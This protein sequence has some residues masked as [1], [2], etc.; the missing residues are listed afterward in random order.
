MVTG[1]VAMLATRV[2]F[3]LGEGLFPAAAAKALANWFPR[4]ELGRANGLLLSSTALGS[5]VAPL[6]VV[7]LIER[8]G[9][10]SVFYALFVP[11]VAVA[12]VVWV[13]V[14]NAPARAGDEV[15]P[16]PHI[17]ARTSFRESLRTPAVLWC[18]L[19]M[20]FSNV[21]AWGLRNWL[22]TY[23]LDARGFAPGKMAVFAAAINLAGVVGYPLG[24]YICDRYFG[25]QLR[26]PIALGSLATGFCIYLAAHAPTG[27]GAGAYLLVVFL[28]CNVVG[29][30]I[31]TVP[32][33]AVP[34]RAV[35]SAFGLMNTAGSFA[36]FVSP[37]L[38]G[39]VLNVTHNDFE[40]ALYCLVGLS[41][42]AVLPA[43]QIRIQPR[44]DD[45][46]WN[47]ERLTT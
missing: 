16:V 2:L 40:R 35:G 11:G 41:F 7:V 33:L 1:Y 25:Q 12:A 43:L 15:V 27:E 9:W 26:I 20:F 42:I 29:A 36:G 22:P 18:T 46:P 44:G 34:K 31:C 28:L 39:Y 45:E 30:A 17:A 47:S 19:C 8:W 37:V 32:L 21:V 24:G 3:G 14:R 6:F 38:I 4:R 10:R 23:L 13:Y 5:T